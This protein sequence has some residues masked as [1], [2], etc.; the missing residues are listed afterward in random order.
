L[1]GDYPVARPIGP[2][3]RASF[4]GIHRLNEI[5]AYDSGHSL[6]QFAAE[7]PRIAAAL[8]A[9]G[10]VPPETAY[11]IK[12]TVRA[13]LGQVDGL[14]F[15]LRD[16]VRSCA[17]EV[18]LPLT[19]KERAKLRE[20]KYD[21][22]SDTITGQ[23]ALL[24]TPDS[25]KLALR[26]FPKLFGSSYELRTDGVAWRA[27]KRLVR[28]RNGFTHSA[29]LN[30]ISP[31][32]A[33]PVLKPTLLW[34]FQQM[35][36]LY[37][38]I[39]PRLGIVLKP[40][41]AYMDDP[42]LGFNEDEHPW[43]APFTDDDHT[44]IASNSSQTLEYAKRLL[45]HAHDDTHRALAEIK[46]IGRP[47]HLSP[48]SQMNVRNAVRTLFSNVEAVI[49]TAKRFVEA[50][51]S[52]G[53]VALSLADRERLVDGEVEDRFAGALTLWSREF[54]EGRVPRTSGEAWKHFRG[55]R[56]LRNRLT[57]P[58]SADRLTVGLKEVNQLL[59]ALTY[60]QQ[61]F[62]LL[63]LNPDRWAKVAAA[64]SAAIKDAV[65]AESDL[66]SEDEV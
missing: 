27:F 53:E 66:E 14:A 46:L 23:P 56:F 44:A 11:L 26:Y 19:T 13:F 34:F 2:K 49:F 60:F 17:D 10:E 47:T 16:A 8:A 39:A 32:N 40:T 50:S 33:V 6:D 7:L 41:A 30:D 1:T 42:F 63:H 20:K 36:L 24:N 59:A 37:A 58:K 9:G 5:L 48:A 15:A 4:L 25:L 18:G 51:A 65:G 61:A 62:D 45:A 12:K 64:A 43:V 31:V 57:H 54:G 35:Q 38:D 21:A 29:T 52:R 3:V 28:T 22:A 55:A